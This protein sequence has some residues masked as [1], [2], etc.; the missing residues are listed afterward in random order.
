MQ[1]LFLKH[2]LA[3]SFLC[4]T[5]V[6]FG[7]KTSTAP[8]LRLSCPLNEA[9]EV[10][11]KQPYSLGKELKIILSSTSDT[12]VKAGVNGTVTNL[13]QDED[14]KWIIVFNYKNYYFWYGGISKPL[15]REDQK[16]KAGDPLGII[17]PG[18][19]LELHIF[20]FETPLDP[21][22]YLDCKW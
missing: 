9:K 18:G 4:C 5:L 22:K 19:K 12:T 14:R 10:F 7:Q 11:E 3:L 6:S 13:Q 1:Q 2:F 16:I 17:A 20:D 8:P 15:V 21:K